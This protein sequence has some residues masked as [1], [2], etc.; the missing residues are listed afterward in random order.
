MI[1]SMNQWHTVSPRTSGYMTA[2]GILATLILASLLDLATAQ[3]LSRTDLRPSYAAKLFQI[4]DTYASPMALVAAVVTILCW[5]RKAALR[6]ITSFSL[7]STA[8]CLLMAACVT[9]RP[10][11][12]RPATLGEELI[13]LESARKDGLL[14]D[15]DL[16]KRR[17]ETIATWKAIGDTPIIEPSKQNPPRE[18]G[19]P[20]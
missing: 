4:V 9:Y 10:V 6:C 20:K 19:A 1:S 18:T 2:G 17:A 7:A 12:T 15:E 11:V 13:S 8:P 14:T 3:P 5:A 16:S